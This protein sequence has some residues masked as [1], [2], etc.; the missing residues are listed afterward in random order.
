MI[1]FVALIGGKCESYA[2][3]SPSGT[4][5]RR[6]F[7]VPSRDGI[8]VNAFVEESRGFASSLLPCGTISEQSQSRDHQFFPFSRGYEQ[9]GRWDPT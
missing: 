7:Q 4:N 9:E 8:T 6:P 2:W 5:D 3:M 1:I